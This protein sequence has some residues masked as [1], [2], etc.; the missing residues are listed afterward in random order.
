MGLGEIYINVAGRNVMEI[1]GVWIDEF[2]QG[3]LVLV[4]SLSERS[5]GEHAERSLKSLFEN[6]FFCFL[7]RKRVANVDLNRFPDARWLTLVESRLA[8][9]D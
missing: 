8:R 1:G 3:R 6:R 5:L 7:G 4:Q 9:T 2:F